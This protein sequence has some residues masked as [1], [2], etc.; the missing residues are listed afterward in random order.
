MAP[1]TFNPRFLDTSGAPRAANTVSV[2]QLGAAPTPDALRQLI[3]TKLP[4]K[5]APAPTGTDGW[6]YLDRGSASAK[7]YQGIIPD[8]VIPAEGLA[9]TEE[10]S[11]DQAK[12]NKLDRV[13]QMPR[14]FNS[15][16]EARAWKPVLSAEGQ[17]EDWSY[18]SAMQA[19]RDGQP[20]FA[21]IDGLSAPEQAQILADPRR[22]YAGQLGM[23]DG[24]MPAL[25]PPFPPDTRPNSAIYLTDPGQ[26]AII[27]GRVPKQQVA[28]GE[29]PLTAEV[30]NEPA[31]SALRTM[32]EMPTRFAS[33]EEARAWHPAPK[34]L[35]GNVLQVAAYNNTTAAARP[36]EHIDQL[37]PEV[38]QQVIADPRLT[39]AGLK[40][41]IQQDA[42]AGF[43]PMR[44]EPTPSG[45]YVSFEDKMGGYDPALAPQARWA[46][47]SGL[48]LPEGAAFVPHQYKE[49]LIGD[50][51]LPGL[52][53]I[54][55]GAMTGGLGFAGNA[56]FMAAGAALTTEGSPLR[57]AAGSLAGSVVGAGLQPVSD[58]I[59]TGLQGTVGDLAA[60]MIGRATVGAATAGLLGGDPLLG[61]AGGAFGAL[62]PNPDGR[63]R[64]SDEAAPGSGPADMEIGVDADG[65]IRTGDDMAYRDGDSRRPP[66]RPRDGGLI[67]PIPDFPVL[68]PNSEGSIS[69]RIDAETSLW[70][71]E[72]RLEEA[73]AL[74]QIPRAAAATNG[75]DIA[76][77]KDLW[78]AAGQKVGAADRSFTAALRQASEALASASNALER[79]QAGAAYQR[80]Q[81]GIATTSNLLNEILR[82]HFTGI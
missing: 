73:S 59:S 60:E 54:A 26:Q 21:G 1:L 44:S 11:R 58:A 32:Y 49:D 40:G 13:L 53:H 69:K 76:V 36:W 4:P 18:R 24:S 30:P 45:R 46:P 8:I 29:G 42:P 7:D 5:A 66:P 77:L 6:L 79:E 14:S 68:P 2:A 27:M 23:L 22:A 39:F 25:P 35:G 62:L 82:P 41:L 65:F 67:G 33:V 81:A 57:A 50:R 70:V 75:E 38:Q 64:L 37:P 34:T 28:V 63:V 12:L 48:M 20:P 52:A 9:G 71:A 80:A 61:G 15:L 43:V 3:E 31:L 78:A 55:A 19:H 47:G 17:S 72:R 51:I 56:A 74:L 10:R 16:D